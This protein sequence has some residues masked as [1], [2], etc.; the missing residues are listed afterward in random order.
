MFYTGIRGIILADA[1]K[2]LLL[3]WKTIFPNQTFSF[4]LR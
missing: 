1:L 2:G 4:N 3:T